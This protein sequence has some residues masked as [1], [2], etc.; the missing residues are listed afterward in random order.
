MAARSK[1]WRFRGENSLL[2]PIRLGLARPVKR[3][4]MPRLST[5]VARRVLFVDASHLHPMAVVLTNIVRDRFR[6]GDGGK[7]KGN[8]TETKG[9][10]RMHLRYKI[11][12]VSPSHG[13][14]VGGW[15]GCVAVADGLTLALRRTVFLLI[16]IE[17]RPVV[18]G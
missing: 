3:A 7:G 17:G 15:M 8:S 5:P 1:W 16:V 14:N 13:R 2:H 18:L 11:D 9:N 4:W 6:A 12:H 10:S